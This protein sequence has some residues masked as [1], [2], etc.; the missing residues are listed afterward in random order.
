MEPRLAPFMA[1]LLG[2]ICNLVI[3]RGCGAPGICLWPS[4]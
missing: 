3:L 1:P 2:P 4:R